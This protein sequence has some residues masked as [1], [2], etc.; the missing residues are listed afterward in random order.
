MYKRQVNKCL[1]ASILAIAILSVAYILENGKSSTYARDLSNPG[2]DIVSY[3][4]CLIGDSNVSLSFPLISKKDINSR[5]LRSIE[6]GLE[7]LVNA[8]LYFD[9]TDV[10]TYNNDNIYSFTL[11]LK[12]KSS[13]IQPYSITVPKLLLSVNDANQTYKTPD[14]SVC[15]LSLIHI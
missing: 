3:D 7:D 9:E 6:G 14:F 2:G 10:I 5:E 13:D 15:N 8:R 4:V 12:N 11:T 1:T